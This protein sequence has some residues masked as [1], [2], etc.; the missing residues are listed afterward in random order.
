MTVK[1]AVHKGCRFCL[2]DQVMEVRVM[3]DCLCMLMVHDMHRLLRR[4]LTNTFAA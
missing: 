2:L 4:H 3:S 1:G